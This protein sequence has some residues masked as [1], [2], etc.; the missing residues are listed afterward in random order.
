MRNFMHTPGPWHALIADLLAHPAVGETA[1]H[2]HHGIPK[3]DH[4]LR[5]VRYAWHIAGWLR[6]DRVVCVR[7]ALVHD[8]DSRLGTLR[9]H[10]AIAARWA[11]AR[12]ESPAVCHA[13]TSHMYPL[14]PAPRTREAWVLVLADKAAT[15]GDA[16]QF[17]AGLFDG[18]SLATRRR[19][20]ASDPWLAT[21]PARW[22]LRLRRR[23][24]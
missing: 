2:M 5:S 7:A 3:A 15:L 23:T 20:R 21:R 14:G 16:R 13:I 6:A 10:G 24:R 1:D 11:A 4:L 12:G 17:V 18:T 8:I 9:T 19:L 22:H